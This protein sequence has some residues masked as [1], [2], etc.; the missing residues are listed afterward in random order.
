MP[1]PNQNIINRMYAFEAMAAQ[2]IKEATAI[3]KALEGFHPPAPLGENK[4]YIVRESVKMVS[5]LRA[6]VEKKTA[7]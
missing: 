2:M 5:K 6:S 4:K 3:R 7:K 1:H